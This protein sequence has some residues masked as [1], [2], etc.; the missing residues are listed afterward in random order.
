[1][2]FQR[3]Q[4]SYF[5]NTYY[6][7]NLYKATFLTSDKKLKTF[8]VLVN[9]SEVYRYIILCMQKYGKILSMLVHY[10]NN[11]IYIYFQ[12][13]FTSFCLYRSFYVDEFLFNEVGIEMSIAIDIAL[14][15]GNTESIVE[16][17]YSVMKSQCMEGGQDNST[18]AL[19]YNYNY[20]WYNYNY[21][22]YSFLL[23][24]FKTI[25]FHKNTVVGNLYNVNLIN[26]PALSCIEPFSVLEPRL[27]G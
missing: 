19:R 8:V 16:S 2:E 14:A 27:T 22:C 18:L 5:A 12:Y 1:M 17:L 21:S 23:S 11:K 3:I 25:H 26:I 4:S 7:Q 6:L 9:E 20:S 13:N 24:Q 10:F 15:L